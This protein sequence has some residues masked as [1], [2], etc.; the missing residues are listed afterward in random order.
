MI[1]AGAEKLALR[2]VAQHADLWNRPMQTVEEF[3]HKNHVLNQHCAA[4]GRDP[5]EI[6]RSVQLLVLAHPATPPIDPGC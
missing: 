6:V 3:R 2:V 5:H 4:I 1:G